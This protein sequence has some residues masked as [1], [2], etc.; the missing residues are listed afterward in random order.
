MFFLEQSIA[1][2]REYEDFLKLTGSLSNLF[3][4]SKTPYL[5]YRVAEKVFCRAF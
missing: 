2:K 3:S 1:Q 4:E 5:Y